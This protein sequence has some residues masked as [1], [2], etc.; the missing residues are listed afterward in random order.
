MIDAKT[1]V[2]CVI[3]ATWVNEINLTQSGS[4]L[5]YTR[6]LVKDNV[7]HEAV[8]DARLSQLGNFHDDADTEAANPW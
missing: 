1:H 4:H 5:S 7:R 3:L 2:M 6:L 8:I